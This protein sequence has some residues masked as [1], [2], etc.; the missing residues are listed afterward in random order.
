MKC[1]FPAAGR[2][3]FQNEHSRVTGISNN[4]VSRKRKKDSN[5]KARILFY[6]RLPRKGRSP[7]CPNYKRYANGD[8]EERKELAAGKSANQ[9]GVGFAEIFDHDPE[10]GEQTNPFE[11]RL[12]KL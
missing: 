11:E 7:F 1:H 8:Q 4:A 6:R 2:Y 3:D 9:L 12:V 10:N 5:P